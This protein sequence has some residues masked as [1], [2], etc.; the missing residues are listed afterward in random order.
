MKHR[1]FE[2]GVCLGFSW[3]L[4]NG[5]WGQICHRH[6]G[7]WF[8][9]EDSLQPLCE[10]SSFVIEGEPDLSTLGSWRRPHSLAF[11]WDYHGQ[12]GCL[13]EYSTCFILAPSIWPCGGPWDDVRVPTS[14]AVTKKQQMNTLIYR[15]LLPASPGR[16]FYPEIVPSMQIF[17]YFSGETLKKTICDRC[18]KKRWSLLF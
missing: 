7:I 10:P 9:T 17:I 5:P 6:S 13:P 2:R 18:K 15:G 12:C 4:L 14:Y 16:L 3:A 8:E 11:E 1:P